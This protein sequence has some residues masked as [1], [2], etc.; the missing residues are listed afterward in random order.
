MLICLK[1]PG[2]SNTLH[3]WVGGDLRL[4][5]NNNCDDEDSQVSALN[6]RISFPSGSIPESLQ[7]FGESEVALKKI[8]ASW[9]IEDDMV[10]METSVECKEELEYIQL[11]TGQIFRR[12]YRLEMVQNTLE[13][14]AVSTVSRSSMSGNCP[15]VPITFLNRESCVSRPAC[16]PLSFQ[17]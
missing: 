13:G 8:D 4:S 17:R 16:A 15:S 14:P 7:V 10:L 9:G 3:E 2:A 11:S 12:D 1:Q 5:N 6:P